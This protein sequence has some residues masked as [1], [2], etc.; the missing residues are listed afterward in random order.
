MRFWVVS[1]AGTEIWHGPGDAGDARGSMYTRI[2]WGIDSEGSCTR[3]EPEVKGGNILLERA[4]FYYVLLCISPRSPT[5]PSFLPYLQHTHLPP[6]PSV[7]PSWT[8]RPGPTHKIWCPRPCTVSPASLGFRSFPRLTTKSNRRLLII[9]CNVKKIINLTLP[10][11][12]IKD[13]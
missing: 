12:E 7:H 5:R 6:H 2:S 4:M 3:R 13:C 8:T 1:Q 10:E 11:C 9:R